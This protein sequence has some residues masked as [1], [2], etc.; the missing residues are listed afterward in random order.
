MNSHARASSF[1][2][3][4]VTLSTLRLTKPVGAGNPVSMEVREY[5]SEEANNM[6]C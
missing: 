3:R 1:A 5:Y 6:C 4:G 2:R